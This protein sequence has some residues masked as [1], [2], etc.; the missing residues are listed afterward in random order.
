MN[1]DGSGLGAGV[2]IGEFEIVRELG[3][4]AF[5]VTYLAR[6]RVPERLGGG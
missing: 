5:G 1:E 6:D 2:R 4:G 3:F